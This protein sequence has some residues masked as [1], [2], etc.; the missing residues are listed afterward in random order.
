[1]RTFNAIQM[2]ILLMAAPTLLHL[3]SKASFAGAGA[4]F[5]V[6]IIGTVGLAILTT[7]L[8]RF[9]MDK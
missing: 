6:G 7:F 8:I 3:C 4:L 1:M 9:G 5:W 2:V